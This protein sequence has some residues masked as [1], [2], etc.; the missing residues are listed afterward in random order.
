MR[1]LYI[2]KLTPFYFARGSLFT[3]SYLSNFAKHKLRG[4]VTRRY[5]M[6]VNF[7][8]NTPHFEMGE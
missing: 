4:Q 6:F 3:V 2:V 8:K 7:C 5:N 1:H